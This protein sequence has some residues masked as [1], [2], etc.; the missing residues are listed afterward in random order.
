MKVSETWLQEWV[1][2]NLSSQALAETLTMAGLEVE[3]I[4]AE[5][6]DTIFDISITPNRG[7][8]L[9]IKGMAR[10]IAALTE[11]PFT[12]LNIPANPAKINASLPIRLQA[13][14][15][16]PHY[17]GRVI[18]QVK[19][20][21][22]TPAWIVKR[23]TQAGERSIS[24]IVDV[25]NYVML[26]L[27][28]PMHAFDL[29]K[30]EQ[31]IVVRQSKAGERLV[32]LDE[33]EQTLDDETLIIA[34]RVKPLAIAGVMG[35]M[36]SGV[37]LAT[38]DIFL[39][40]AYFVPQVVAR[41]RQH[42][43]L[44]SESAYRFER[45]VD[46]I[47]Q[48]T[49]IERATQLILQYAGGEAGP[50]LAQSLT[51]EIPAE[52]IIHLAPQK[53]TEL[54]GVEIP[55][56]EIRAILH[57]LQFT[58]DEE[59]RVTVPSYRSD[60]VLIEDLIE[61]IARLYGYNKIPAR[62][63]TANLSVKEDLAAGA[64]LLQLRQGLVSLAYHEIITYSFVAPKLQHLLD[65]ALAQQSLLNP[66]SS[67][68][69][70]MRSNLWPGLVSTLQYNQ[71]RQQTL[72]R[73]FEVGNVFTA[74]GE[75]FH[76]AGLISGLA[77]E[78]QWGVTSRKGDFFDVKGDVESLLSHYF[79][80]D[81]LNFKPSQ[82]KQ[83][84]HPGQSA[85]IYYQETCLGVMGKLHPEVERALDLP[86]A[87][88]LFE[89]DIDLIK[90]YSNLSSPVQREISK[91][92]EIRRDISL[93]LN[94]TIPAKEIQATIR[95]YAGDWLKEV[96]VFDV[97]QGKG[98]A[99]GQKSIALGLILQHPTRTLVDEEVDQLMDKVIMALKGQLRAEL[100]S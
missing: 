93:L 13:N 83:V 27:G 18:K 81:Q 80:L 97:Y 88:F 79:P 59:W 31:E 19:A 3:E 94:E 57:R 42:Y 85:D 25:T 15:G 98:I 37:T 9:S 2:P 86:S 6:E 74:Q 17:V 38:Q 92:P 72:V 8:C 91:F 62:D 34:D 30:I 78:E 29:A 100:R 20:D 68:M 43:H 61:E 67:E 24:L 69:A 48:T 56:A 63:L 87:A 23:L 51:D 50:V 45:G 66:I 47:L 21:A 10:E 90:K 14:V 71:S 55:A 12:P 46:P 7:D 16:C 26:E 49:A 33:T 36:A 54:L 64:E 32:L 4:L 11:V 77:A 58:V 89:L 52:K 73:L 44:H 60:I 40:S 70:V 84:L 65:P 76:V 75:H 1:K 99:T 41:V 95:K 35:G 96:F 39:E 82:N 53:V 5:A 22:A 28:Q